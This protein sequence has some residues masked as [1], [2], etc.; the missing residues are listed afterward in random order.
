[1]IPYTDR[2]DDIKT[3]MGIAGESRVARVSVKR[4]Q[5]FC[6]NNGLEEFDLTG[7][8]LAEKLVSLGKAVPKNAETVFA[9]N[10][11]LPEADKLEERFLPQLAEL[12]E[13]AI[14]RLA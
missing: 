12:C 14:A 2:P 9:E 7:S 1:M 11:R 13:R 3:A 8:V 10:A 6:D 4:L 5:R